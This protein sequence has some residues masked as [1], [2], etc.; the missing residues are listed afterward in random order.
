MA[1]PPH[2]KKKIIQSQNEDIPGTTTKKEDQLET[3]GS[4]NNNFVL[5]NTV[6]C[7][8][9]GDTSTID[10]EVTTDNQH[11]GSSIVTYQHMDLLMSFFF[12]ALKSTFLLLL[13]N[14]G[15]PYY[16]N[17]H[18]SASNGEQIQSGNNAKNH[19]AVVIKYLVQR[20]IAYAFSLST[21][22]S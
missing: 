20:K 10:F 5:Q 2:P 17:F 11:V 4:N 16:I 19:E 13:N 12:I 6:S 15:M 8:K 9:L 7:D 14:T 1:Y 18:I 21:K 3:V 22:I